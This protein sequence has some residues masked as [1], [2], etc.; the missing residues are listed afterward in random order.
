M[1][2]QRCQDALEAIVRRA[3]EQWLWLHRR[4]K[5]RPHLEAEWKRRTGENR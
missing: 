4:W 5:E 1:N 3:P 2:T